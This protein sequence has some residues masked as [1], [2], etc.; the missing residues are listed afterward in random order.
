MKFNVSISEV[1][2]KKTSVKNILFNNLYGIKVKWLKIGTEI[3]IPGN[4]IRKK[5]L[6]RS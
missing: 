6:F 3:K 2:F 4:L 5:F 1:F